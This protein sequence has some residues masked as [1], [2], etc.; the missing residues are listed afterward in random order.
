MRLNEGSND[1]S[2]SGWE[3]KFV[4]AIVEACTGFVDRQN[5]VDV[6]WIYF[7]VSA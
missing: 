4:K 2:V 3:N 7:Y 5:V 1:V 6:Q